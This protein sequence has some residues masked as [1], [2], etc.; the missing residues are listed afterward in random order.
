MG[1]SVHT[2]VSTTF[3]IGWTGLNISETD[4]LP[5]RSFYEQNSTSGITPI[6]H[7]LLAFF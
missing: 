5:L 6:L 1:L 4:S 2:L 3:C 7:V